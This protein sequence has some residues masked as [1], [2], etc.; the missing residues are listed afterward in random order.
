MIISRS[1]KEES[2]MLPEPEAQIPENPVDSMSLTDMP[3]PGTSRNTTEISTGMQATKQNAAKKQRKPRKG[4]K[5]GKADITV[6]ESQ[7][8]GI[9][10]T[11]LL[12]VDQPPL[13]RPDIAV[14]MTADDMDMT[15][16]DMD[17]ATSVGTIKQEAANMAMKKFNKGQKKRKADTIVE[18]SHYEEIINSP[19]LVQDKGHSSGPD[20]PPDV[21]SIDTDVLT[22]TG[23][24]EQKKATKVQRTRKANTVVGKSED[25]KS[26]P[27]GSTKRERLPV[28]DQQQAYKTRTSEKSKDSSISGKKGR[29]TRDNTD[30]GVDE[31]AKEDTREITSK[32]DAVVVN[33]NKDAQDRSKHNQTKQGSSNRQKKT[34][35]Q[36]KMKTESNSREIHTAESR[37]QERHP[38]C[39]EEELEAA[40]TRIKSVNSGTNGKANI[41][42][43]DVDAT[44]EAT[45]AE[46]SKG[47]QTKKQGPAKRQ[48]KAAKGQTKRKID[49][50][51]QELD[52]EET[53]LVEPVEDKDLDDEQALR[54][55]TR[56]SKDDGSS[57][58]INSKTADFRT[59]NTDTG[60]DKRSKGHLKG[61]ALRDCAVDMTR[62]AVTIP[63]HIGTDE[64][65]GAK[66]QKT[67][68]KG[69]KKRKAGVTMEESE[70]EEINLVESNT[71]EI[72][73]HQMTSATKKAKKCAKASSKKVEEHVG[74][75]LSDKEDIVL[76]HDTGD[77]AL[78]KPT[79]SQGS[80]SDSLMPPTEDTVPKQ[81]EAPIIV[82]E[83]S[84]GFAVGTLTPSLFSEA[85][86]QLKK[87]PDPPMDTSLAGASTSAARP[88]GE[89]RPQEEEFP[90][91]DF[92]EPQPSGESC[93]VLEN[94]D[95]SGS[96]FDFD[97]ERNELPTQVSRS[98]LG[99][100]RNPLDDLSG[101]SSDEE[102][103]TIAAPAKTSPYLQRKLKFTPSASNVK[104]SPV[105]ETNSTG[106]R[107]TSMTRKNPRSEEKSQKNVMNEMSVLRRSGVLNKA[108]ADRVSSGDS[109]DED[110][111][112][113]PDTPKQRNTSPTRNEGQVYWM[114]KKNPGRSLASESLF[115]SLSMNPASDK[116]SAAAS[117]SSVSSLPRRVYDYDSSSMDVFD[118]H[119]PIDSDSDDDDLL[120]QVLGRKV[121]EEKPK[122]SDES[123]RLQQQKHSIYQKLFEK[124]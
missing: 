82:D 9:N 94:S 4:R 46:M 1:K 95:M 108:V 89:R 103:E 58:E 90:G 80:S 120:P 67:A 27:T 40:S 106:N 121:S 96:E 31:K 122:T 6:A 17:V 83:D 70:K 5:K 59:G 75:Q 48:K 97:A 92:P 62:A 100:R 50:T 2:A 49:S 87:V 36:K 109:S 104:V 71:H 33:V 37:M 117:Q 47:L 113:I 10:S 74:T 41:K 57:D 16:D 68:G 102:S 66:G 29:L 44:V 12:E 63:T 123:H 91:D 110:S 115:S 21:T 30:L 34:A 81:P 20:R 101:E 8:E 43:C 60:S 13:S 77:S 24:N 11:E 42:G 99:K 23:T 45:E 19:E 112:Y 14:D 124:S 32:D 119:S 93:V 114:S 78:N 55:T 7:R 88:A 25:V 86:S 51:A 105:G 73:D 61:Q 116:D 26:K 85:R 64:Q 79:L 22:S 118:T 107:S 56:N 65:S 72:C 84:L 3:L 35:G 28:C 98:V 53:N 76:E 15:R 111:D 69:R 54:G 52:Q 39:D 38:V 18:E